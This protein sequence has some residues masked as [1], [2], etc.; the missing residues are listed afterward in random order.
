MA[1][2]GSSL[3]SQI[4][5]EVLCWKKF[6]HYNT[7]FIRDTSFKSYHF[8]IIYLWNKTFA[9]C[10][11]LGNFV[12]KSLVKS[13]KIVDSKNL[14]VISLTLCEISRQHW[15]STT[16]SRQNAFHNHFPIMSGRDLKFGDFHTLKIANIFI[17]D[18]LHTVNFL[19]S[20]V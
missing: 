4:F 17:F 5:W 11:N 3:K 14:W 20:T 7:L 8:R 6:L 16:S 1:K 13:L 9:Q 18:N 15:K 12:G 10:G 2:N 19:K